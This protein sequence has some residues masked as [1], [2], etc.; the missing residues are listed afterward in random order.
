MSDEDIKAMF[1]VKQLRSRDQKGCYLCGDL[2]ITFGDLMAGYLVTKRQ[3]VFNQG[4]RIV[5]DTL[6]S[7]GYHLDTTMTMWDTILR[8]KEEND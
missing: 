3:L 1:E 7:C 8:E 4:V 6:P 5:T 2:P